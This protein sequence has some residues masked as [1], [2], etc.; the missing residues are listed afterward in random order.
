MTTSVY[1]TGQAS[2]AALWAEFDAQQPLHDPVERVMTPKEL[3]AALVGEGLS[4]Y[5][6]V[7]LAGRPS[8]PLDAAGWL[9]TRDVHMSLVAEPVPDVP[10]ISVP[11]Q[12]AFSARRIT[13]RVPVRDITARRVDEFDARRE[14]AWRAWETG[15]LPAQPN[16]AKRPLVKRIAGYISSAFNVAFL[17]A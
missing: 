15:A 1:E 5:D 6:L 11:G 8:V 14:A 10:E 4:Q 3:E 17:E 9:T 7:T 2:S 16:M 13:G 12:P